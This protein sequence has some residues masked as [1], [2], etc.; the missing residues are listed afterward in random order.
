MRISSK[1]LTGG[2]ILVFA[3][4][5]I[6]STILW[7]Q[8]SSKSSEALTGAAQERLTLTRQTL[9]RDL[10]S[11]RRRIE[12]QVV[13]KS[14]SF[15]TQQ[16]LSEFSAG[17]TDYRET[18]ASDARP[19]ADYYNNQFMTRYKKSNS[20]TGFSASRIF[21]GM[22]DTAR[23]MQMD[24]IAQNPAPLGNKDEMNSADNDSAYNEVHERWH[25]TFRKFQKKFGYYDV[26]LVDADTDAIVYSVFKEVDFGTSLSSGPFSD[27]GIAKAYRRAMDSNKADA[28]P[29]TDFADYTPSYEAPAS[30]IASP[31]RIDGE[32]AGVLIFQMPLETI[33]GIMTFGEN[34]KD[35]GL[36]DSGESYLVGPDG[37][38]RSESRFILED[39]DA[40]IDAL[41]QSGKPDSMIDSIDNSGTAIGQL[42]IDSPAVNAALNGEAGF[43]S[44]KDYRGTEVFSSYQPFNYGGTRW[45]LISEIDRAEALGPATELR[46]SLFTGA[47]F[48][49]AIVLIAA[50]GAT[51][52]FARTLARPLMRTEQAMADIAEGEGDLTRRLDDQRNDEIGAIGARFNQFMAK[53]QENLKS[54]EEQVLT[55]SS[56]ASELSSASE[57]NRSAAD[58]QMEKV[59]SAASATTEMTSSFSEVAQ[60]AQ[61]TAQETDATVETCE[62]NRKSLEELNGEI[63]RLADN[64]ANA[65][66]V[67]RSADTRSK[68]IEDVLQVITDIADQTNLLAL[69]AAI[70]AARAGE[71]GR[72]FAV[73]ADEVRNLSKS[74]Q[75]S[76]EEIRGVINELLPETQRAANTMQDIETGMRSATEAVGSSL[77]RF[78]TITEKVNSVRGMNMQVASATEEQSQVAED[79]DRSLQTIREQSQSISQG[80]GEM[81]RTSDE[82]SQVSESIKRVLGNFRF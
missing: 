8:A 40:F 78:D 6:T 54:L 27:S 12:D 32:T 58:E 15:A 47:V 80:T 68:R 28:A 9:G 13:T 53:L 70:E 77:E 10:T 46:A 21:D 72:G 44:F 65:A 22:N 7:Q 76:T 49:T 20:G 63:E 79:I 75:Q 50:G 24:F 56:A 4:I 74:T 29:L 82:L 73:V 66:E 30:F 37:K 33:T 55:L 61:N 57:S 26:F 35:F 18:G 42:A 16:A 23:A 34:W 52:V 39:K 1:L 2:L 62:T 69:N 45:A 60:N 43:Q 11:T 19:L 36:G 51:F 41:K 59:E 25:S 14:A 17:F 67:V 81:T 31:I 38:L 48:W 64:V 71:H 5:G 3:G